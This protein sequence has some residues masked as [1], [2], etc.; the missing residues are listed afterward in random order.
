MPPKPPRGHR[1][2]AWNR[3]GSMTCAVC[4]EPVTYIWNPTTEV[5]HWQHQRRKKA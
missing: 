3:T 2:Q 1:V 5:S 4:G